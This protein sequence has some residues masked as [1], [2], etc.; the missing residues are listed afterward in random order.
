[1]KT[2]IF[3][4]IEIIRIGLLNIFNHNSEIIVIDNFHFFSDFDNFIKK[5][6]VDLIIAD[7]FLHK[8]FDFN[9]IKEIKR[10]NKKTKVLIFS[11]NLDKN[12][13][14]SSIRAGID[15][16]IQKTVTKEEI[17]KAIHSLK[18]DEEYFS[19]NVSNIILK[20]YVSG[21]KN[22]NEISEKK[23]RNLTRREIQVLRVVCDGMTNQ[24]I[25][26]GLR[27]SIRTVNTH[28][29][30]IMQKLEIK[31]TAELIKFAY[32]NGLIKI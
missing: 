16:F 22:G 25:A 8:K 1:M 7:F 5:N 30:N 19:E 14:F 2:V 20:S 17:L 6:S 11:N 26:D 28:K 24:Q 13:I 18:N 31:T 10:K 21:I 27:I 29:N 15:G 4:E 32:K 9:F 12:I 3:D 23:P